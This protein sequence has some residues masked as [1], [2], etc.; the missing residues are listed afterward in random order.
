MTFACG[1]AATWCPGTFT[2]WV[3]SD[4]ISS[5]SCRLSRITC[6]HVSS[7]HSHR[8][9]TGSKSSDSAL[10]SI[11]SLALRKVASFRA[12]RS[13]LISSLTSVLSRCRLVTRV[14]TRGDLRPHADLLDDQV[15]LAALDN[16]FYVKLFVAGNDGKPGTHRTDA[17]VIAPA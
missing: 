13:A 5:Y 1:P 15:P 12:T 10:S 14:L 17:L 9:G 8:N 4:R 11:R 7:A 2:K 16:C 6:V 3:G